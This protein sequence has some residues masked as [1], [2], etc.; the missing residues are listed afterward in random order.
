V[1]KVLPTPSSECR[2]TVPPW[3]SAIWRTMARPRPARRWP[4]D[5]TVAGGLAFAAAEEAVEDSV[6]VF[7][8]DAWT[9][10]ASSC[11]STASPFA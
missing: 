7:G 3:D 6:G 1:T 4:V 8:G 9:G 10:G 5:G 11:A 2:A